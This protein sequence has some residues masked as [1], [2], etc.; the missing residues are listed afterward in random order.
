[1]E[2]FALEGDRRKK[3]AVGGPLKHHAVMTESGHAI[4]LL[5]IIRFNHVCVVAAV[6]ASC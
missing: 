2:R 4:K 5:P 6:A 1:M 3:I